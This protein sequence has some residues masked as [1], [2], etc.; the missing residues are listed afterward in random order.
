MDTQNQARPTI[1]EIDGRALAANFKELARVAGSDVGVL[2]V[3]KSDAYGHGFALVGR[4]LRE[5]GAERFGVATTSEGRDLRAAGVNG[6]I[7]VLGG[8]YPAEYEQVVEAR[9]APVVWEAGTAE[10]LAALAR[11]AGRV[12][13]LH[14]KVDTGMSRLGV[15]PADAPELI[16]RLRA[17]DGVTVEGLLTHFCNAEAVEGPETRRQ[18]A[19]FTELVRALE[20]ADLLPP[21]VHAANSAATLT[22]QAA[23][24]D[25]VRPGLA[26]Y[27]VYP[28]ASMRGLATLRPAMRFVTGIVA[29]RSLPAGTGVSYGTTFVTKRT[30]RIATLPAGYADGYP[31]AL[32]NRGR[33]LV[34]GRRVPVVGRVCMDHTMIDVT[35]V[36]DVEVGDQVTLWGDGLPIEEVA[37]LAETI[38]YELLVRVGARVPR[39]PV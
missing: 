19:R 13:T 12:V 16:Q 38:P 5:A 39:V 8:V 26:L 20:H 18:L 4:F 2:P 25:W 10:A 29:L 32:S 33:V 31:R 30:S 1:A 9:L 11:E 23:H 17:I 24:F 15:A 35:D 37:T 27:G 21:V 6:T 22:T 28:S 14:V 7:V 34:R 3:M 36:P